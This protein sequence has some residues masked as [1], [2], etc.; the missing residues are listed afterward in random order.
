MSFTIEGS[1]DGECKDELDLGRQDEDLRSVANGQV[2][3]GDHEQSEGT[4]KETINK[5]ESQDTAEGDDRVSRQD[6]SAILSG[7]EEVLFVQHHLPDD[8]IEVAGETAS[9]PDD[10]PSLHVCA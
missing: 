7:S 9:I 2:R 8:T 3:N 5:D 4:D 1:R 10:T 6:G